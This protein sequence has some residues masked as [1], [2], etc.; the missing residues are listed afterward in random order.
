MKI[1]MHLDLMLDNQRSRVADGKLY[2]SYTAER[3][4]NSVAKFSQRKNNRS[5]RLAYSS[6]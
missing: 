3:R 4:I 5:E 2:E 1:R 6:K